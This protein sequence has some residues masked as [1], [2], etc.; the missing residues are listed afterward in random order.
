MQSTK[1]E[2]LNGHL[3]SPPLVAPRILCSEDAHRQI[4]SPEMGF[5]W[6]VEL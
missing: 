4:V 6:N 1:D 2:S 5:P 3:P